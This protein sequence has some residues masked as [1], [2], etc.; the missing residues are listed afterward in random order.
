MRPLD[1]SQVRN[2]LRIGPGFFYVTVNACHR[3]RSVV[4]GF[5]DAERKQGEGYGRF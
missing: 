5:V 4:Y 1:D 2:R 3:N